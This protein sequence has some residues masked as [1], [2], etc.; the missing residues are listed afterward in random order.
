[1]MGKNVKNHRRDEETSSYF[2][3]HLPFPCSMHDGES[4]HAHLFAI[5]VNDAREEEKK[6]LA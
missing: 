1:M 2:H 6:P 5:F 4:S 3:L